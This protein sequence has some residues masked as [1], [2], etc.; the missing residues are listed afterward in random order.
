MKSIGEVSIR[1]VSLAKSGRDILNRI[2]LDFT[3]GRVGLIGRNGSGKST[4]A[5]VVCGLIKPDQGCV[6]IDGIDVFTDRRQALGK[7]GIL[8]QNPDHQIIFPTVIEEIS[9]GL[10]QQGQSKDSARQT[11]QAAL[12][13][14]GQAGWADRSISTLSQGQR[15]LVCLI[16]V[17]VM[18]PAVIVLDEPFTGLDRP[19]T[20]KLTQMLREIQQTVLHISHDLKALQDADRVIW[21]EQGKLKMDGAPD[22]V[23]PA[24]M[25]AM[26]AVGGQDAFADV[27]D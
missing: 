24:Y 13:K 11:S 26:D 15:H 18:Q 19:T 12:E 9:F 16:S 25:V 7:V 6:L 4:L 27:T 14:F 2:N 22:I 20:G 5:R 8:F 3:Y 21:I 17:L 10:T 23:L 1:D